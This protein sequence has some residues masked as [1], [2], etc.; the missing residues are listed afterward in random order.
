MTY[1][2]ELRNYLLLDFAEHRIALYEKVMSEPLILQLNSESPLFL[3]KNKNIK[4]IVARPMSEDMRQK[5]ALACSLATTP[6]HPIFRDY[7]LIDVIYRVSLY[8][9]PT[10]RTCFDTFW[11]FYDKPASRKDSHRIG[12]I[13]N[14]E[15]RFYFPLVFFLVHLKLLTQCRDHAGLR[16]KYRNRKS[17][18]RS[19]G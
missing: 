16:N 13:W 15:L 3:S 11:Y 12:E 19:I 8:I 1:Q 5:W 7:V 6:A 2:E 10:L 18:V 9:K 17:E 14:C 4:E